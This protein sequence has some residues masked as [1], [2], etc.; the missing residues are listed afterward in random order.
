M[1]DHVCRKIVGIMKVAIFKGA[2][3]ATWLFGRVCHQE[4]ELRQ[5]HPCVFI[6][7]SSIDKDLSLP[8]DVG[9]KNT[10]INS[11]REKG[12]R[13]RGSFDQ[14]QGWRRVFLMLP[15]AGTKCDKDGQ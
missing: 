12:L 3:D 1:D 7:V 14:G 10:G 9:V 13:F 8:G 5:G 2:N 11:G 6:E 15:T 4:L